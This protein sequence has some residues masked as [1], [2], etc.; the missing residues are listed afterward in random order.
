[1][2]GGEG[3]KNQ[4]NRRNSAAIAKRFRGLNRSVRGRSGRRLPATNDHR[5]KDKRLKMLSGICSTAVMMYRQIFG[6]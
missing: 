3:Y 4:V 5:Q 1:M 6:V 2:I